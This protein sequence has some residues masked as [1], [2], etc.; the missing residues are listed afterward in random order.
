MNR[1]QFLNSWS[2]ELALL[3]SMNSIEAKRFL[4]AFYDNVV[5]FIQSKSEKDYNT[6]EKKCGNCDTLR[7]YHPNG[8]LHYRC[9]CGYVFDLSHTPNNDNQT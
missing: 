9:E 6:K 5:G 2:K 7:E 8:A 1:D 4:H 3:S